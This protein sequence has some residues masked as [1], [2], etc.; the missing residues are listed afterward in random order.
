VRGAVV[1]RVPVYRWALPEDLE[2]LRAGVAAVARGEVDVA[3]FTTGMQ[4]VHL[5][6]VAAAMG[7]ED[8]VRRALARMVVVS[9]GPAT[10][11]ELARQGLAV[12]LEPSH[13]KMGFL[14]RE[15]AER[16]SALLAAKRR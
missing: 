16:T 3:A 7:L 11:E 12:D 6:Q 9:I 14:A 15:A 2:P 4:A 13:P 5:F 8:A 10:S 1:T